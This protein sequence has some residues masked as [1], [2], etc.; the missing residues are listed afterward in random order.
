MTTIGSTTKACRPKVYITRQIP[1]TGLDMLLGRCN[2]SFWDSPDPAS[3]TELL[4]NVPGCS[5]LICMP[6]DKIDRDILNAAGNVKFCIL[7]SYCFISVSLFR[8]RSVFSFFCVMT[9]QWIQPSRTVRHPQ[10]QGPSKSHAL[11]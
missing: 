9:V 6:T 7:T 3:K 1:Q 11:R 4:V 2:V 10:R 8:M 5:V